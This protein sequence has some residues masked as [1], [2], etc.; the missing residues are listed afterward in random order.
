MIEKE[1][2]IKESMIKENFE[3]KEMNIQNFLSIKELE[4]KIIE[5]EKNNTIL[6]LKKKYRRIKNIRNNKQN[7]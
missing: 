6:K 5:L 1:K 2:K 7:T 4:K 3:L